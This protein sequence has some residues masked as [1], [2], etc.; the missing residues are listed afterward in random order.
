MQVIEQVNTGLLVA[1]LIMSAF[2]IGQM[3]ALKSNL[4]KP[5]PIIEILPTQQAEITAPQ[6]HLHKHHGG[7]LCI[8][9]RTPSSYQS[10]LD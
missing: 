1:L 7:Y 5:F 10:F 9:S 4:N 3:V 8:A 6:C 2:Q